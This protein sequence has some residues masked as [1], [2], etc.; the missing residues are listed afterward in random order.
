MERLPGGLFMITLIIQY[1]GENVNVFLRRSGI[2]PSPAQA[3]SHL[4]MNR[5]ENP[6]FQYLLIYFVFGGI[7]IGR[8][9]IMR[10]SPHHP[11]G[12]HGVSEATF[13]S[14]GCRVVHHYRRG[15]GFTL[16]EVI[17]VTMIVAVLAAFAVP[18]YMGYIKDS[19]IHVGNNIAGSISSAAA[20]STQEKIPF[21]V[22]NAPSPPGP[23]APLVLTFNSQYDVNVKNYITVPNG[24][25]LVWTDPNPGEAK[26]T[27]TIAVYFTEYGPSTAKTFTYKQ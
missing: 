22:V 9:K 2:F 21:T 13:S 3:D 18:L 27:G 12:V 24:F 19:T 1:H 23:S 5:P 6:A 4:V 10:N 16:V 8:M 26:G 15:Q 7:Y 14:E 20:T 11:M 17:V 25:T